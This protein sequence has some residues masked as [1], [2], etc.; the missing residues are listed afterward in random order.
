MKIDGTQFPGNGWYMD[1]L[2][3]ERSFESQDTSFIYGLDFLLTCYPFVSVQAGTCT[4]PVGVQ[5]ANV[6]TVV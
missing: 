1:D 2:T 5:K 3:T 4:R 6:C